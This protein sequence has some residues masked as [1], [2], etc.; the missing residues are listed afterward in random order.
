MHLG[1]YAQ[2]VKA[3]Q[4]AIPVKVDF[5]P[6]VR[7]NEAVILLRRQPRHKAMRLNVEMPY[8]FAA[9][10]DAFPQLAAQ[11]AKDISDRHVSVLV[12][13]ILRRVAA[14]FDLQASRKEQANTNSIEP[15]FALAMA[16]PL[17][18][19]LAGGDTAKPALKGGDLALD[20]SLQEV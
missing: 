12:G 19:R 10:A 20:A 4:H 15:A 1:P 9:F 18:V 14:G 7:A 5:A 2:P 16:S 13:V 6:I 3:G 17:N 8:L 11:R